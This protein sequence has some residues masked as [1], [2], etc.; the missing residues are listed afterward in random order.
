MPA[1]VFS[2]FTKMWICFLISVHN[3]IL[4]NDSSDIHLYTLCAIL[5]PL[6]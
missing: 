5:W 3:F 2:V 6:L 1:E 4:F